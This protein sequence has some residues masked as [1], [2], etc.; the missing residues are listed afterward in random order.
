MSMLHIVNKSPFEK[1]SLDSCLMHIKEGAAILFI[2]DGI[3]AALDGTIASDKIKSV[4]KICKVY[5]LEPDIEARG[6]DKGK[7]IDGVNAIGYGD[8]VDLT[9]AYNSVHSWV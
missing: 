6:M 3:Y 8:F 7:I 4:L 2:E 5:A 9:V 1:S